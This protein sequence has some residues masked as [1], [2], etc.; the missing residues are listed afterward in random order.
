MGTLSPGTKGK[1]RAKWIIT[2]R[3]RNIHLF[4]LKHSLR[5]FPSSPGTD[6]QSKWSTVFLIRI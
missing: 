3:K 5:F 6:P 2:K 1:M 4:S